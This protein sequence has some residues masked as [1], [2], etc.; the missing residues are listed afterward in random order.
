MGY[1]VLVAVAGPYGGNVKIKK[2]EQLPYICTQPFD[3]DVQNG[4]C[5]ALASAYLWRNFSRACT[6]WE[7]SL[8][9]EAL[10]DLTFGDTAGPNKFFVAFHYPGTQSET[11]EARWTKISGVQKRF[12]KAGP[13]SE[14]D[15]IVAA[16]NTVGSLTNK[17]LQYSEHKVVNPSGK[18]VTAQ[19]LPAEK[20]YW[21]I[22][23][24]GHMMAAVIREKLVDLKLKFF[25]PNS[26]QAVFADVDQF[27]RFLTEYLMACGYGQVTFIRFRS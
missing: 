20:G 15:V 14:D 21:L 23:T 27:R 2:F 25:D 19:V 11:D 18:G 17:M 24:G 6:N 5:R 12:A 3:Q 7:D 8:G 10:D 4:V 13:I 22:S 9:G 16:K 1:A 26:G